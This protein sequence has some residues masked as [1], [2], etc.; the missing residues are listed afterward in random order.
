MTKAKTKKTKIEAANK[1]TLGELYQQIAQ[2]LHGSEG[3]EATPAEIRAGVIDYEPCAVYSDGSRR[4]WSECEHLRAFEFLILARPDLVGCSFPDVEEEGLRRQWRVERARSL[5]VPTRYLECVLT[6]DE[7]MRLR[8]RRELDDVQI[9]R[10]RVELAEVKERAKNLQKTIE[11][12]VEGG[13]TM[14]RTVRDGRE[15]R[16]VPCEDVREPDQRKDAPTFGDLVVVTRRLDTGEPIA[17]R[18]LSAEERQG[19]LFDVDPADAPDPDAPEYS[20]KLSDAAEE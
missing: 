2:K 16:D 5:R 6:P 13:L 9:E 20:E 3:R 1:R 14:S 7:I 18:E 10:V 4:P 19:S 12:L 17:W 11:V 8:E 15:M